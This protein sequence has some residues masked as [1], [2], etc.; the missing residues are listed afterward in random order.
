MPPLPQIWGKTYWKGTHM[1]KIQRGDGSTDRLCPVAH[2]EE[3]KKAVLAGR[4]TV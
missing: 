2:S 4:K 3:I 1:K